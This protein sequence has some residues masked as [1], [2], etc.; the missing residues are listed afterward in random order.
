MFSNLNIRHSLILTPGIAGYLRHLT[1]RISHDFP[2]AELLSMRLVCSASDR[3]CGARSL[4]AIGTTD[5]QALSAAGSVHS[6]PHSFF[7]DWL[8][9]PYSAAREKFS[10]AGLCKKM[11]IYF[12][13]F[14]CIEFILGS[15]NNR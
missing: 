14:F 8:V 13:Q 1:M 10:E 5:G 6:L 7:E 3:Q 12:G 11:Q 9:S 4:S 15:L 2:D